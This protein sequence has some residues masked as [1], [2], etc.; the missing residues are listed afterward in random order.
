[1]GAKRPEGQ[2]PETR[3]EDLWLRSAVAMT[4]GQSKQAAKFQDRNPREIFVGAVRLDSYLRAIGSGWVVKLREELEQVDYGRLIAAYQSGGRR[5][6]HPRV[7]VGLMVYGILLKQWSLRELEG[8]AARDVG[9]WFICGGHQPDHS[10]I[11]KFLQMHQEALSEAFFVELT[12]RLVHRLGAQGKVAAIDGTV[13]EAASSRFRLLKAEAARE[14]AKAAVGAA[15]DHPA[16]EALAVA[17]REAQAVAE[18]VSA[19]EEKQ[20]AKGRE[21]RAAIVPTEAEAVLQARK[22]GVGRPAY[23]PSVLVDESGLILAQQV[24]PSSETAVVPGLLNQAALATGRAVETALMDAG[25]FSLSILQ[26]AVK[27]DLNALCPPGKTH[28]D[29]WEKAGP[30][31]LFAKSRFEFN[32]SADAYRCP[33]NQLL[34]PIARGTERGITYQRYATKACGACPLHAQ[35]TKGA[36]RTVKRYAGDELKDAMRQVLLQP[37][38]RSVYRRRQAI[39][40]PAF[41][42]IR[43]RQGLR[44]FHRRG[45]RGARLEFSLHCL[46]LNL[47]RTIAGITVQLTV[48]F[49]RLSRLPTLAAVAIA[50]D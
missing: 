3:Q 1:M 23:K 39:V 46:A 24:D 31:G 28:G 7:M 43:E 38:A 22:D 5:P 35:C 30:S 17:A 26:L 13:I 29:D 32:E 2:L 42:E 6:F 49:V 11:G 41:A 27:R 34:V 36:R 12:H 19:R 20:R 21:A 48:I 25:Y 37:A 8:L 44:R 45:L 47:K 33:A 18:I 4:K 16:D 10:T 14:M 15:N 40:E 9:A 50:T